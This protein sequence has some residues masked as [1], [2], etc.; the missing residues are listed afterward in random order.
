MNSN[1][2]QA[3]GKKENNVKLKKI[4]YYVNIFI[5]ECFL[6]SFVKICFIQNLR[7]VNY[8]EFYNVIDKI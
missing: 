7:G 5:K 8:F 2:I 1:I 4:S 3:K 6:R